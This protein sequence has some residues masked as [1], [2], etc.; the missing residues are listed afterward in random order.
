LPIRWARE[1]GGSE[2][3]Q[4][5]SKRRRR[6]VDVDLNVNFNATVNLDLDG[7]ATGSPSLDRWALDA[8]ASLLE[9]RSVSDDRRFIAA[10]RTEVNDNVKGGVQVQVQVNV[11]VNVRVQPTRPWS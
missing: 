10:L 3:V 7:R 2:P 1:C 5:A 11:N 8:E 4:V 9:D 6:N